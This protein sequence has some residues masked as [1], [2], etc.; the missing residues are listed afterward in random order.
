MKQVFLIILS[1]FFFIT[2]MYAQEYS[3]S[4]SGTYQLDPE[5]GEDGIY[6]TFVFNGAGKVTIH[7]LTEFRGDFL[8]IGDTVIVYPDKSLFTFLKKDDQTLVGIDMWVKDQVFR[9]MENDTVITPL[10]NRNANYAA[11]FYEYYALTGR[12]APTLATYMNIAMDPVIQESM[13]KLCDKGFPRACLTMANALLLTSPEVAAYFRGSTSENKKMPPNK[14]IFQYFMKA[15]ELDELNGIAQLG[16]Y[17]LM[18]GHTDEAV[19]VFEK[20]CELGHNEC[21]I[22]LINIEIIKEE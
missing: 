5:L 8:Q 12:E 16:S 17:F 4:L 10:Q 3:V 2:H 20:G 14:E 19:K 13:R 22:S 6:D 11:Q 15:I 7:S 21:C 1:F 9:K 18:L